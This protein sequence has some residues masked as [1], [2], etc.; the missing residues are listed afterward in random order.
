MIDSVYQ[1]SYLNENISLGLKPGSKHYVDYEQQSYADV[2]TV[3]VTV[4]VL[5]DDNDYSDETSP[6]QYEEVTKTVQFKM[7]QLTAEHVLSYGA[8][9]TICTAALF[10]HFRVRMEIEKTWD[11]QLQVEQLPS[12]VMALAYVGGTKFS[13]QRMKELE[14]EDAVT[15][16]K[17]WATLRDFLIEQGW[18]GTVTP[19]YKEL[20]PAMIK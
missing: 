12:Y 18:E 7:N 2:T 15:S 6:L 13:L 14:S 3:E 17:A 20:N 9:D 4:K 16:A 10:N 11:L 19:Q 5:S 1:A 8:D